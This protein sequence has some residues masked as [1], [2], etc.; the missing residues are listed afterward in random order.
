MAY[1]LD[2]ALTILAA[3]GVEALIS[4]G[5]AKA[6]W[7]GLDRVLMWGVAAC[8]LALFIPAVWNTEPKIGI[9][10][11]AGSAH[12]PAHVQDFWMRWV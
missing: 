10:R 3:Y 1:L 12:C 11:L 6:S 5:A 4:A 2:F 8:G 9:N 7:P